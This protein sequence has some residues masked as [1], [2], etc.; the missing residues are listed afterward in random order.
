[1]DVKVGPTLKDMILCAHYKGPGTAREHAV[2]NCMEIINGRFVKLQLRGTNFLH[3]AEVKVF[4]YQNW[5]E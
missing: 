2:L 3:L 4:A 1:M 5:E